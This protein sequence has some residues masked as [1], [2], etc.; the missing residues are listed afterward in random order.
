M[1]ARASTAVIIIVAVVWAINFTAPVF[2]PGY[3]PSPELNVAFMAVVATTLA[4]KKL[5]VAEAAAKT[6]TEEK[7]KAN[8]TNP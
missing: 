5:G 1:S 3:K 6:P 4:A 7:E 2:I 8:V